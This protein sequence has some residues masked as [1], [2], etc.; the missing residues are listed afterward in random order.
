MTN[1]KIT[2]PILELTDWVF[3]GEGVLDI[4]YEWT[5]VHHVW[6]KDIEKHYQRVLVDCNGQILKVTGGNII[7]KDWNLLSFIFPP[8]LQIEF[9][10]ELT[11]R[12]M[13]IDQVKLNIISKSAKNYH[14][15]HN[16]LMTQEEYVSKVKSSK[17]FLELF[18]IAAFES[19]Q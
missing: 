5:T 7:G 2:Y 4:E 15:T 14:I 3:E 17:T 6:K 8:R 18:K 19:K 12:K 1:E 11:S 13:T 16:K 10:V 9:N